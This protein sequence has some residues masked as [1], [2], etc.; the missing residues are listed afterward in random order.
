MVQMM[1]IF[2]DRQPE[3]LEIGDRGIVLR[4]SSNVTLIEKQFSSEIYKEH[5]C[6]RL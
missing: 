5:I 2:K 3:L 6:L 4:S 1:Y